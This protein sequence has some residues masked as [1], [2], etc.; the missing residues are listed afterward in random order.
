MLTSGS[1]SGAIGAGIS[2]WDSMLTS[3]SGSGAIG[4]GISD[5]PRTSFWNQSPRDRRGR[6]PVASFLS[7]LLN[8]EK[9]KERAA[10]AEGTAIIATARSTI[11]VIMVFALIIVACSVWFRVRAGLIVLLL[12]LFFSEMLLLAL[13]YQQVFLD[14]RRCV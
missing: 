4:A 6:D 2:I 8:L 11:T 5:F 13:L 7:L 1:G 12:L 9:F 14:V 3:G 10:S